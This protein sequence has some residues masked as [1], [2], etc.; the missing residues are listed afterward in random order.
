M[1]FATDRFFVVAIE[2]WPEWDLNRL[3]EHSDRLN[4]QAM[5]S[6]RSTH[7]F[8][9]NFVQL[10]RFH[11]LF[12]V[13]FHFGGLPLSVVSFCYKVYTYINLIEWVFNTT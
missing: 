9:A 1:V 7:E 8:R 12:S 3:T 6:T 4:Y 2:S 5:S 11:R 13:T 10:L